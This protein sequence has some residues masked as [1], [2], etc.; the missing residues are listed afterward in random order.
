MPR[1]TVIF[2]IVNPEQSLAWEG[3]ADDEAGA[4]A[5]A[6]QYF[7][8]EDDGPLVDLTKGTDYSV[9]VDQFGQRPT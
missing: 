5:E 3:N 9:T 8:G 4:E 2:T 6:T 1:Y 7:I